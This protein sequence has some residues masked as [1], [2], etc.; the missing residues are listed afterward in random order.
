MIKEF[1]LYEEKSK[2]LQIE[3][4]TFL[5]KF[6]PELDAILKNEEL[7]EPSYRNES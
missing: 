3:N 7:K 4:S 1:Y 6:S 2:K 5:N